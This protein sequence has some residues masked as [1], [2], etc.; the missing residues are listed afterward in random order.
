MRKSSK[1]KQRRKHK[2][3]REWN[4]KEGVILLGAYI[5]GAPGSKC[6]HQVSQLKHLYSRV[7]YG[8]VDFLVAYAIC[9]SHYQRTIDQ[10]KAVKQLGYSLFYQ[11]GD[12]I[13]D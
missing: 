13:D 8:Q 2:Y 6:E 11:K 12:V 4:G 7:E 5:T 10:N 3:H 1:L 9:K